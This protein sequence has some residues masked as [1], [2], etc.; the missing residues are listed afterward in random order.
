MKTFYLN[1]S[2]FDLKVNFIQKMQLFHLISLICEFIIMSNLKNKNKK[3]H[4]LS[5]NHG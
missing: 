5:I 3:E 4:A 2:A 1:K